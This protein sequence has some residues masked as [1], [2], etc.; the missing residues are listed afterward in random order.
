MARLRLGVALL[1]PEPIRT[2]VDALRK[3]LGDGSFQRVPAHLTLVPPVN[4]HERDFEAALAILRSA[5]AERRPITVELGPPA[6]FLPDNPVLFLRA[7]GDVAALASLRDAVFRPPLHR[8]LAWPWIP[9]VTICD[10]A[11]PGRIAHAVD[12]LAE[13]RARVVFDAVHVLQEVDRVWVPIAN[14][15][16]GGRRVVGRGGLEL[17]IT[18]SVTLAPDERVWLDAEWARL[19]DSLEGGL[20]WDERPV[21]LTARRDGEVVGVA[22]GWTNQ[23]VGY[24]S[25]L[26]VAAGERGTGVGSHLL[27]AF[28]D[29]C[30]RRGAAR[31]A[32]RTNEGFA[33][34]R[35][36]EGRGW[37]VEATVPEWVRGTPFLEM[38]KDV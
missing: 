24:L 33:A 1:V 19:E 8:E 36:Y 5:A 13:Y 9:H 32:L 7:A 38:R 12:A 29:L 27:A 21:A 18:E 16:L 17:E 14:A 37:R 2:E 15:A 20:R 30:R 3:S 35:F 25:E 23:G 31:L 26:V 4:V 10:E 28:E 6:T 22:V 11:D 34:Q